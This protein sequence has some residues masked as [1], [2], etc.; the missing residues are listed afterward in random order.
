MKCSLLFA[1]L[2][3]LLLRLLPCGE[4]QS[5][6]PAPT[7]DPLMLNETNGSMCAQW[8]YGSEPPVVEAFQCAGQPDGAEVKFCCGTCDQM[9]NCS[10]EE[11]AKGSPAR[12]T[13][14]GPQQCPAS[15]PVTQLERVT[16]F[17]GG[18]AAS[19]VFYLAVYR[20]YKIF[21]RRKRSTREAQEGIELEVTPSDRSHDSSD[22]SSTL[23]APSPAGAEGLQSVR[24]APA[25][26]SGSPPSVQPQARGSENVT[27][28]WYPTGF[29]PLRI[30]PPSASQPNQGGKKT[31]A[32]S[33]K[34]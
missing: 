19:L 12:P 30:G 27:I 26:A 33:E 4:T 29:V 31:P 10:F 22:R 28:M 21:W 25:A 16:L 11:L 13:D 2:L 17:T 3:L 18:V 7:E 15:P 34:K 5:T 14:G 32:R 20:T 8:L 6:A 9:R 24:G 1:L 23:A